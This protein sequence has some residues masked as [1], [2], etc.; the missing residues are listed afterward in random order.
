MTTIRWRGG[1]RR[2][3]SSIQPACDYLLSRTTYPRGALK[4]ES[5]TLDCKWKLQELVG[6][7]DANHCEL[8][9]PSRGG[10][11]LQLADTETQTFPCL[12]YTSLHRHRP[13]LHA[14]VAA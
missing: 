5:R 2:I 7:T 12:L 11:V 10:A 13:H 8:V 3:H 1:G 14:V 4:A 9:E 6:S